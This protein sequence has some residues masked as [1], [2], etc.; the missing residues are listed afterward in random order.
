M[1]QVGHKHD[2]SVFLQLPDGQGQYHQLVG[3][4]EAPKPIQ[5]PLREVA[6]K[7]THIERLTVSNWLKK[8]QRFR[9]EIDITKPERLDSGMTLKGNDYFD[10]RSDETRDYE[11]ELYAH[12]EG[13]ILARVCF[14]N[15]VTDEH[16]VYLVNF[17]ITQCQTTQVVDLTTKVRKSIP[18][19]VR[20][21]NPLN[22]PVTFTSETRLNELIV[23]P[24]FHVPA[25]A[26]GSCTFEFQPLKEG[27]ST[28]KLTFHSPELGSY[29]YNLN[30]T[31]KTPDPEPVTYFTA[32]LG[33]AQTKIIRFQNFSKS[34]TEFTTKTVSPHFTTEKTIQSI[35]AAS[36]HGSEVTFEVHFE[37]TKL[38]K[39][40]TTL[41]ITSPVGG[42]YTFPFTA[43]CTQPKPQGPFTIRAKSQI[44]IPFKNVFTEVV[45]FN[46]H[47]DHPSFT[48]QKHT[49]QIKS[50][51]DNVL[52]YTKT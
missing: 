48:L 40:T 9:V 36:S 18:Y 45:D 8:Q 14:R 28:G 24:S 35:Q 49:E 3:T 47:T 43:V 1:T 2:A 16:I 5:L 20:I 44:S 37:P 22:H 52:R 21:Q 13:P 17:K 46:V 34:K 38:G 25:Q 27:S 31:A 33:T 10:L 11:L 32:A 26:V 15:Q 42:E 41:V 30:F 4:A 19:T 29:F 51:K 6:A 12:R 23:P 7:T 39:I 50:K